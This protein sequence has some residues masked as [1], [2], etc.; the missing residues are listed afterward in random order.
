MN[1]PLITVVMIDSRSDAHPDWVQTAINSVKRQ[2][3]P[4]KLIVVNNVGRKHTIGKCWND[5]VKQVDTPWVL[6]LGDDD[7]ITPDYCQML[8]NYARRDD[9]KHAV[10][11][12]THMTVFRD[13][14]D[15]ERYKELPR[16]CTGMWRREYLL[17]YPFNEKLPKGIDR[18]YFEEAEKRGDT[19]ILIH[20]HAGYHYRQHDDYSCAGKIQLKTSSGDIYV[21]SRYPLHTTPIVERLK[22]HYDV[23]IDNHP[24]DPQAAEGARVIWCDW[25]N[26]EAAKISRYETPARKVLRIHA[27]EAYTS[28]LHYIDLNAFD[29]VIFVADHIRD[30]CQAVLKRRIENAVVIPNGVDLKGFRPPRGKRRNH[31]IAY[32]G[33]LS[34]KKGSQLLLFMAEHFPEYAFHVAG[35]FVEPDFA[36]YWH[37]RAPENVILEPYSYDLNKFF[38]DKTYFLLTSPREGCNVTTLQ[39]MAAGLKPLVYDH[40]GASDIFGPY[41]FRDL[42][43]FSML[44]DEVDH[45]EYRAYVEANYSIEKIFEQYKSI[46]D[47]LANGYQP[48]RDQDASQDAHSRALSSAIG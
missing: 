31:R 6:F 22:K 21:N 17:Q 41:V 44:L 34:R 5:A 48:D 13:Y 8:S 4:V 1:D 40:V 20:Y 37:A 18:E 32:A 36:Q 27:Y 23:V 7:W 42:P 3:Y 9:L 28:M 46:F 47:E 35:K 12:T 38:E 16:P 39:A 45:R 30:Y 29:K 43:E 33:E 11:V 2:V 14:A 15:G 19:R 24:F 10:C 25:G 26:E